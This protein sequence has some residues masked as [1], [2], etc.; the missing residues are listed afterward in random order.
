MSSEC[1]GRVQDKVFGLEDSSGV[2]TSTE[3]LPSF[4]LFFI[5]FFQPQPH[6]STYLSLALEISLFT[7]HNTVISTTQTL[8]SY[9]WSINQHINFDIII[10]YLL[11][12]LCLPS[13]RLQDGDARKPKGLHW[14]SGCKFLKNIP[15]LLKIV[16]GNSWLTL[17]KMTWTQESH[18]Q[19]SVRGLF[20]SF[21]WKP[22]WRTKHETRS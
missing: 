2:P 21:F 8:I 6:S 15:S 11:R 14:R 4:P 5:Q 19:T 13:I 20:F 3:R 12:S 9:R 18:S 22:P 1:R 10:K 16:S 7:K 17:R